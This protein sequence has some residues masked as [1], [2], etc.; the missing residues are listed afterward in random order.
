M[1]LKDPRMKKNSGPDRR[2]VS[3][4]AASID[5][6]FHVWDAVAEKPL[7]RKVP[8]RL[9]NISRKGACLQISQTLMDG[10]HLM[11]DNDLEGGTPLILDLPTSPQGAPFT[12]KSQVLWYNR[13]PPQRTVPFQR[14]FEVCRCL[15][16]RAKTT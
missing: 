11:R 2:S 10:Y 12:I 3:R 6:E 15:S 4:I 16:Y 13:I 8:G 1:P 7:T 14:R 9:T 5:V